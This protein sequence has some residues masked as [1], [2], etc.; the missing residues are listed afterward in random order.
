MI[1]IRLIFFCLMSAQAF[2]LHATDLEQSVK[3]IRAQHNIVVKTYDLHPEDPIDVVIPCSHKDL[4]TLK[5]A[6]KGIR[7][8]GA[9]VRRIIILS[10]APLEP[11]AEWFDEALFPF[12]KYS[13]ALEILKNRS[14]ALR[15]INEP[16]SRIGW[17]YQQ[18]LKLYAPIVIPGISSNVLVL[19]ADTVFLNKTRFMNDSG[20][21][22]LN[23]GSEYHLPYFA[24]MP[25]VL[26]Y[27][28]RVTADYS[29][30]THHMLFQKSI[31][32]DFMAQI[33]EFHGCP[34]WKAICRTI[35]R[36]EL[37][38]SSFSE[39]EMYFNFCLLNTDQRKIR[40]L[41][42]RNVTSFIDMEELRTKEIS[43]VSCHDWSRTE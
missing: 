35:D 32:Q 18:L 11:D 17:I 34:M 6:V 21:V 31:I 41:N 8:Y 2:F 26:P 38:G 20:A 42:W 30:V 28:K 10:C 19:D 40:A 43:Y 5:A 13:V 25:K 37:R 33:E 9:S 24:H 12:D 3:E 7:A 14:K 16:K 23:V 36:R 39:Y 4:C 1:L 27:L 15:F 22:L 29:G